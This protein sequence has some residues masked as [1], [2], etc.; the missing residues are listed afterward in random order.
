MGTPILAPHRQ[1]DDD[2]RA[3]RIGD[4]GTV[5]ARGTKFQTSSALAGQIAYMVWEP[6]TIQTF[7]EHGSLI[8]EYPWPEPSTKYVGSGN[9]R[10]PRPR[11]L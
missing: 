9:S 2:I 6:E 4:N 10:G 7:D 11:I 5:Y 3:V 1:V 8:V